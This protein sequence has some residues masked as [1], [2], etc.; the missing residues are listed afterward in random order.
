MH[1]STVAVTGAP[2]VND[3]ISTIKNLEFTR[4]EIVE[5]ASDTR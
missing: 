3:L 5:I 2:S 4:W 1:V